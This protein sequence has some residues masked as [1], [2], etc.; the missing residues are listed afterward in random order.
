MARFSTKLIPLI[1]FVLGMLGAGQPA[2]AQYP[3]GKNKVVY[4]K[5]EWKV[6]KTQNVDI[7]YYPSEENLVA[8]A[9]PIVEETFHEFAEFF[10]LEFRDA[11]P[12]VFYSSHHD[13]QQTNIIP[14]LIS[15]YTAGFTD[16]VK[17]RI[18]IPFSGSLWEF[19]HVIRHEMVHAFMLEKLGAVMRSR[20]KFSNSYPPLW[21]VEGLAE[22][23]ASPE[24]DTRS[25]MFIR[26]ALLHNRLPDLENIWRIEGSFLMY[27]QG[28]AVVRYIA[29]NYGDEAVIQIIEN[30]W[31]SDNFSLVLKKTINMD[32]R[33][34]NDAFFR[35]AKRRYFPSILYSTFAADVGEQLT[36]PRTFHNRPVAA[37][38][39]DGDIVVY[40][41]GAED[42]VISVVKFSRD[43]YGRL[44]REILV[45]GSLSTNFES[46]PAF[47]SKMEARG[48]TLLFVSKRH[49]KDAVY[50]WDVKR[51]KAIDQLTFPNL[52]VVSSPTLSPDGQRIVFSAIDRTGKMDLFLY[53]RAEGGL[54]RLT[55][56]SFAEHDPDYHPSKDIVIFGSDRCK[57]GT[58]EHQGIYM[59]DV[60]TR[61]LTALTCG[62]AKDSYPDWSPD[63][64]GFLF[65][66]DRDDV[67]NVY[68]YDWHRETVIKQT[69]VLGGVTTP[70]FL[71]DGSGFVAS[72]YYRGEFHLFEFPLK[73]D[74]I[75]L[76]EDIAADAN[77]PSEPNWK[78][79]EPEEISYQ[80][81]DYK[82]K[83]GLDFAGAG[84]AIDPNFG[85]LGNGGQLVLTDILGN[86]QFYIFFANSSEGV[87]DFFKRLNLGVNYVNLS[88]RL[89]YS[90][91]VF[92]LNSYV[93]DPFLI[94][95]IE[96][97][98]GVSGGL[99][100]PFSRF[101]RVDGALVL[102]L[103][104][105]RNG[106]EELGAERSFVGT[107]FLSHVVDKTLWT[108]GGPL[109]GWRYYVTVGH[110]VDFRDR[111]FESTVLHFDVRK[112]FKITDRIVLAERFLTRNSYGTDTEIFYLGGPWDFR[113]YDFR[114][115]FGRTTYLINN[116][117]RFP[118]IDRFALGLPFGTIE[119][120]RMR[121]ALFFDLGKT[122]R[123]I[124]DTE[125]LGSFG[126]GVE[127][128]LG[129][130][131]VIRVNFTR[132]TD[133]STISDNTELE[134]FIGYNY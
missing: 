54:E 4:S 84:V 106:F 3:Y 5:R 83:L 14:S 89:H 72:G 20:G 101:S 58:G 45:E 29:T 118:L 133:F 126:G 98:T 60:G 124:A 107:T 95:R 31:M 103:I 6:L 15:D 27:K 76:T 69:S 2:F 114:E 30:W 10:D 120:P 88:R 116:E 127:L 67:F 90:L 19:R 81:E 93:R 59:I 7:Y 11:L 40:A 99:S 55:N 87:D 129:Y 34:L 12:L 128:N 112:Y 41:L 102:R 62:L 85:A 42:G 1:A 32:L 134:L 23:V 125:W 132:A 104:E 43:K 47:R 111:G 91:G 35:S 48:D 8:F 66:S 70:S 50:L 33:E 65:S 61:Q 74:G 64:D 56:D 113:G 94:Y 9:A 37:R 68:Y 119:T 100:F 38:C 71:P 122:S 51:N 16:L 46:I 49:D 13:F 97:R 24:A 92:H 36:E 131:P 25:H 52:S 53:D 96:E 21:F 115:F 110:T 121:G 77:E 44:T 80:T 117:L 28:E 18:A 78:K 73:K 17:G 82:M 123:F 75:G 39:S 86:H 79:R 109:K 108:I 57:S 63:G 105:R 26:D 130:A 22:Y